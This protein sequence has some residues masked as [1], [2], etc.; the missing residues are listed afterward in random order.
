MHLNWVNMIMAINHC[1][2]LKYECFFCLAQSVFATDRWLQDHKAV[3]SAY[4]S[5]CVVGTLGNHRLPCCLAVLSQ[6]SILQ[7][8]LG[9]LDS[10]F[11][12]VWTNPTQAVLSNTH[13]LF[14]PIH[15]IVVQLC[16]IMVVRTLHACT[17]THISWS[18]R[19]FNRCNLCARSF[20]SE[21]L[22][23]ENRL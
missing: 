6:A 12:K 9:I 2:L 10:W 15:P 16:A 22:E 19:Y 17:H 3:S 7:R 21:C 11:G 8:V 20:S 18:Y 1:L 13:Y 14:W 5:A 23:D 4:G